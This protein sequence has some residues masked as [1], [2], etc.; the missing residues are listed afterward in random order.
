MER[1]DK[2]N[3][4]LDL[5]EIVSQRCTCIR[6]HYGAVIVKDDVVRKAATDE[7]IRRYYQ[8]KVDYKKGKD[9]SPYDSI[10]FEGQATKLGNMYINCF[11]Q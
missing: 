5:A 9:L 11:K 1:R 10:W 2:D 6:R 4:Y 7:I 8:A 3:Y